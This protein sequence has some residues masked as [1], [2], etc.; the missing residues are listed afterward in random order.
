MTM[1]EL[2]ART[3]ILTNKIGNTPIKKIRIQQISGKQE[4][5]D[6]AL[7]NVYAFEGR[8]VHL[9][10]PFDEYIHVK[11]SRNGCFNNECLKWM[12]AYLWYVCFDESAKDVVSKEN[13]GH[14]SCSLV[15][16]SAY[17][18]VFANEGMKV[19]IECEMGQEIQIKEATYGSQNCNDCTGSHNVGLLRKFDCR[20]TLTTNVAESCNGFRK[21]ILIAQSSTFGD[22]CPGMM[23]TLK[24]SYECTDSA[25]IHV[26]ACEGMRVNLV[27]PSGEY[28]HVKSASYGYFN[29]VCL[30]GMD[31]PPSW[32]VCFDG[33]TKE[34]VS[35][36]C[37]GLKSCSLVVLSGQ[38]KDPCKSGTYKLLDINYF[39]VKDMKN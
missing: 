15:V 39:C 4:D 31:V 1:D 32:D 7:V 34:F 29:D 28:I 36:Q 25:L 8:R 18:N 35:K 20:N 3:K 5:T 2:K 16:L 6:S 23:K 14:S 19:T 27:C 10:C 26:Y 17:E 12:D 33:S 30:K 37:D 38:F 21:C 11:S 13:D 22:P 24:V 9:A